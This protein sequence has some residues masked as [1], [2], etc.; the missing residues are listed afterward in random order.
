MLSDGLQSIR[1]GEEAGGVSRVEEEEERDDM[2]E[3]SPRRGGDEGSRHV[4]E[5]ETRPEERTSMTRL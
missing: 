5:E 1:A 3:S 2:G 4:D